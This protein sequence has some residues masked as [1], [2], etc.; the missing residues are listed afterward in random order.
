MA[1]HHAKPGETV[2]LATWAD[3]LAKEKTKAIVKTDAMELIRLV[4]SAGAH[5]PHHKVPGPITVQCVKG[6][7]EFTAMGATQEMQAGELLHLAPG[8]PHSVKAIENAVILL[9]IIFK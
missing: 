8:E 6:K 1:T 2:N 4:L 9:T 5:L 3:D 7:I